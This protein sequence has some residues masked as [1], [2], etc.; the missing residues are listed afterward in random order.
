MKPTPTATPILSVRD[1]SVSFPAA[2]GWKP[3]VEGVSFDVAERETVA[4]VGESG[5]GKSV[6]SL[7]LMRL[8]QAGAS[9]TRGTAV[10]GG[11][12]LLALPERG[13]RDVRGNEIAMIFQ[14]PMTSLNPVFTIGRQIS[15]VLIRHRG[16]DRAAARAETVRALDKVRIPNAASRVDAYP[17]EFSGGMRQRVMI[18]MA[19]A[20][21]PR[22]LIAD[23][24]TTA[25]DVTIQGQILDLVTSLQ[26]EEGMAVLFIT[27][28]MG[29]V[30]EIADRTLVMLRGRMVEEGPTAEIFRGAREPYTRALLAS[31][32]RLGSMNGEAAPRRFARVDASSGAVSEGRPLASALGPEGSPVLSVRNL[33]TRF[34]VRAGLFGRQ[35]GA[36]HAV[37]NV[38][39]DLRAGETLAIVGESGCGKSTTGRSVIRLVEP[40]G[41]QVQLDGYDVRALPPAELRRMRQS[42]QM[43]F[44]DPFASLNPRMSVGETVAEPFLSHGLGTR[45]Q[46]RAVAVDL[47]ERVGMGAEAMDRYPHEFSGGQRQRIAIARALSLGPKVIVADE[48]VSALDVSIKVQVCNLMLDLQEEMGLAYLF[49]S[50]DMAVVERMSHRVAVMYLGEIVEIGPRQAIF[51]N[52]RHPYTRKLMAA[53]PIPDPARRRLHQRA[54][55]PEE[56]KSPFRPLGYEP[57]TRV[58]TEV[59]P[60]HL[61]QAA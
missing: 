34:P 44:Q 9:R 38:S 25:L 1:L 11:R 29:V 16:L 47:L 58:Y 57:P 49:I 24:P 14:E 3:V 18:A 17:H 26:A 20:S 54:A 59:S 13:M 10:M 60:G 22:L 39:F 56:L 15:E 30:A 35:T 46:A 32:P 43:I 55:A 41:G 8:L 19:L 5:S 61:V 45:A 23:E 53:V 48:A 52:P 37:E 31:V 4:I 27:H 50:H 42:A 12:D 7:A 28:D 40:T 6:T 21:R 51:E 33:V 36:V 2:G